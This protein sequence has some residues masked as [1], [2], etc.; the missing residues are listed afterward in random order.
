MRPPFLEMNRALVFTLSMFLI[1]IQ[2]LIDFL[3]AGVKKILRSL[4]PL[5]ITVNTSLLTWSMF[6]LASSDNRKA[7]LR[8]MVIM[9]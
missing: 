6:K 5:P 2:E 4:L 7:Q 1:C 8:K 3:A 9:Q